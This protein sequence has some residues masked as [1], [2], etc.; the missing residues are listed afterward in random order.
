M[1]VDAIDAETADRLATLL[2]GAAATR[3]AGDEPLRIETA[4]DEEGARM[5]IIVLGGLAD[6]ARLFDYMEGVLAS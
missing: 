4:Y 2:M 5:K 1:Q 3:G 6:T